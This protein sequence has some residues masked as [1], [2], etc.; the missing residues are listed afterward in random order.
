MSTDTALSLLSRYEA[1]FELSGDVNAATEIAE[2]AQVLARRLKYVA[3]VFS[4]RYYLVESAET[5]SASGS[6]EP[7]A[8]A[9]DGHRGE[10]TVQRLPLT[11]LSDVERDL[12][13]ARKVRMLGA[14]ELAAVQPGLPAHFQKSD[15][16]QVYVCPRFGAGVL[17]G[18]LLFSKRRQPFNDLDVKFLTLAA[19]TFHDKIYLLREQQKRRELETAYLE[20]EIMLRQSEKL[21]TLGRLSAGMAHEVNNPAAAALR[22]A[23]QLAEEL[24]RLEAAIG[25]LARLD[26]T[27]AQWAALESYQER[28]HDLTHRWP[29]MDA[30][31][32]SEREEEVEAWLDEHSVAEGWMLAP[33][34][35]T[36]GL[37]RPQL[38]QVAA[39]FAQEHV[40]TVLAVLTRIYT[41][42]VLLHGIRASTGRVSAIVKAL[43][44]YSYLDQA[45][46]QN[47]DVHE[48]LN[49]TLVILRGKLS[50]GVAVRREFEPTLPRIEAYGRELNQVWTNLIDNAVEAMEGQG[51]L[52]VRTY[53]DESW[54]VVEIADTGSGVSPEVQERIFDPFFTTK[55]PGEGTGLGLNISHNIVVQK[56]GGR[57]DVRSKPGATCFQVRLPLKVAVGEPHGHRPPARA[58]GV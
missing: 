42:H 15:I 13:S 43:K 30:L 8:L 17:Q 21:A 19:H 47:V 4:W 51:E 44:S 31:A 32:A 50:E 41:T 55:P 24:E 9:L 39:T 29:T 38:D 53:L 18:L 37:D 34:L 27:D 12:W 58:D 28:A 46:L 35:V 40:A 22:N 6:A 45:P 3:D 20:Q 2:V 57:I 49:D 16:V 11:E 48:G 36:L 14:G 54:V 5:A 7:T 26:L 1:L 23:E 52:T 56:H 25:A 33:P 10:A